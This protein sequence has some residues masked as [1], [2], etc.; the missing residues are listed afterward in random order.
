MADDTT[1]DVLG[2]T[3]AWLGGGGVLA[4]LG[5]FLRGYL[6]GASG[7]EKEVREDLR[8]EVKRLSESLSET[9][10]EVDALRVQVRTL[11]EFNLHVIV[12]RA[13]ARAELAALQ[14]RHSEPLTVWPADPAPPGSTP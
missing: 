10:D 11:S 4:G 14:R 12:S 1:K 5:V 3:V 13:E 6:N 9:R 2:T 8:L 7:Q